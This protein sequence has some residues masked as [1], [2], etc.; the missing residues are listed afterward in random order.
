[1]N[2]RCSLLEPVVMSHCLRRC[3]TRSWRRQQR[4]SRCTAWGRLSSTT[5]ILPTIPARNREGIGTRE[6][7]KFR[8][9]P[10]IS[11]HISG[12]K[13]PRQ[14]G[15][16]PGISKPMHDLTGDKDAVLRVLAE[17]IK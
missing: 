9:E 2:Q 13:Y 1:M 10:Q 16:R 17:T 15:A 3:T 5:L 14:F 12:R 7:E 4:R 8:D 6:E 11:A